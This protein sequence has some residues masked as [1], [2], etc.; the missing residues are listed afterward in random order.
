MSKLITNS[1]EGNFRNNYNIEID[2]SS[3]LFIP[4]AILQTKYVRTDKHVSISAPATGNGISLTDLALTI[5][6]KKANSLLLMTWML[7]YEVYHDF[8]FLVHKNGALL[9][10][11]GY[12]GYNNL[13]GNVSW[14]GVLTAY[15]DQDQDSTMSSGCLKFIAPA[16]NLLSRNYTPAVRGSGIATQAFMLNR[17]LGATLVENREI[18]IST[19]V[20][21]EI[22]Q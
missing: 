19:G 18:A 16:E 5:T 8:N 7:N 12:E 13:S 14:S 15:Y 20:I 4:G 6:P 22:A 9:T 21:M 2:P 17:T 3:L 1:L 10:L 11:V